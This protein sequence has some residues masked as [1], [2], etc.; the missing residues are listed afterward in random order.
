VERQD[1][2]VLKVCRRLDLAQEPLC[3]DYGGQFGLQDLDRDS[4]VVLQSVAR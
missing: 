3:A 1:V 4:A 2:W